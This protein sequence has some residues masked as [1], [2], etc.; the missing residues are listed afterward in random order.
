MTLSLLL[1]SD[2]HVL[3]ASKDKQRKI[4]YYL[5]SNYEYTAIHYEKVA[6]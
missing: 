2:T 1:G 3:I 6:W 5:S 4:T